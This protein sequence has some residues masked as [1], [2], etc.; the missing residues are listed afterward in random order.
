MNNVGKLAILAC[1]QPV[2]L[3]LSRGIIVL[4]YG[5]VKDKQFIACN[6]TDEGVILQMLNILEK[7]RGGK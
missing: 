6:N 4:T 1:D 2:T 7:L 5:D 3:T